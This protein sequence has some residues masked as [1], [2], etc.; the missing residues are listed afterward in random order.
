[1]HDL[2]EKVTR[3][4]RKIERLEK[5][6]LT[7]EL[8]KLY[9]RKGFNKL[10]PPI[11]K[12]FQYSLENRRK[13]FTINALSIAVID[14][15]H[16]K[17]VNDSYGHDVGDLVLVQVAAVIS[18]SVRDTDIVVRWGGEE[19][20]VVLV[21]AS[22]GEAGEIANKIRTNIENL[23]ISLTDQQ[24]TITISAGV[25]SFSAKTSL[26]SVLKQADENLYAAKRSGRNRVICT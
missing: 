6:L 12:A 7:D 20:V 2:H 22:N 25:A 17:K 11:V 10:I 8:T 24:L 9:N 15:D 18:K 1:M 5:E 13:K 3:L 16:F 4:E 26:E 14:I 21:G 23:V 19:I